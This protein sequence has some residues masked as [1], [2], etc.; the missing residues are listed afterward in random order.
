MGC[1]TQ[2]ILGDSVV[3]S[4]CTHD[5]DTGVL[6]DADAVPTYRIY[7]DETATAILN[8]SMAKLDDAN[9]TGFYAE[10][11]ACT[12][13][14]GFEDGKTYSVYVSATVDSDTGG[15][16]YG[17]NVQTDTWAAATRTLTSSSGQVAAVASG[18][19]LSAR[20]GDTLTVSLTSLG[21]I[22]A[23][24]KLWFSVKS[25][26]GD[27]DTAAQLQVEESDGLLYAAA[28]APT[29]SN[30]GTITVSDESAG[31]LSIEIEAVEM[32]KLSLNNAL[33]YDVQML[34]TNSDVSTLATGVFRVIG[35]I[36]RATS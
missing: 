17:F 24:S 18:T 21:D 14:N 31:D 19:T 25:D 36:T 22:S 27:A 10:T 5:P 6:T 33:Y 30:N 7:E 8:G 4:V 11:I 32:A 23:R 29:S 34:D 15:I 3:F 9:T 28:E 2:V 12:T 1:P 26:Y 20:R 35:D 13:A 16:C